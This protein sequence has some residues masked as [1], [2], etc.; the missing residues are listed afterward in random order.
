M[1]SS[2]LYMTLMICA[3]ITVGMTGYSHAQ[4]TSSGSA[5]KTATSSDSSAST[6]GVNE[7]G[8]KKI[9]VR[10]LKRHP[11]YDKEVILKGKITRRIDKNE[12]LFDD[13]TGRMKMYIEARLLSFKRFSETATVEITGMLKKNPD[14]QNV[15]FHATEL[16]VVKSK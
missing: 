16:N 8:H 5:P 14:K 15:A 2:R 3:G 9:T 6:Q 11:V 10:E 7:A 13:S 12:Y 4:Y 1:F